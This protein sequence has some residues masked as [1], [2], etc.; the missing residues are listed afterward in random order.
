MPTFL[1]H[2]LS[3]WQQRYDWKWDLKA[4]RIAVAAWLQR[5]LHICSFVL[6]AFAKHGMKSVTAKCSSGALTQR[7]QLGSTGQNVAKFA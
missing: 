5:Y 7:R 4:A 6:M 2:A 1:Q 3:F